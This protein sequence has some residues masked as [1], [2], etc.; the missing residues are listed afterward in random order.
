TYM[1]LHS[2]VSHILWNMLFLGVAGSLLEPRIGSRAFLR[3]YILSGLIGSLS[4]IFHGH[5]VEGASGAING[6]LVALAVY[7]PDVIVL[8]MFLIPMKIKWV[9]AI[10]LGI[11]MLNVMSREGSGT[12]SICHLLGA[13][14]GFSIAFIGPRYVSPWL[15]KRRAERAREQ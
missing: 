7:M 1:L 13:A 12:D 6:A 9:V 14:T 5:P 15:S 10:F 8:F 3:I 4:P 2:G 11:D